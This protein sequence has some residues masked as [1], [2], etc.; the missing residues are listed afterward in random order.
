M[1]QTEANGKPATVTLTDHSSGGY[2]WHATLR[3]G[4]E[5]TGT[6]GD[7]TDLVVV[8]G[9]VFELP[10]AAFRSAA[11]AEVQV[12]SVNERLAGARQWLLM[13]MTAYAG[14]ASAAAQISEAHSAL[15]QVTILAARGVPAPSKHWGVA[16]GGNITRDGIDY[17]PDVMDH[18]L[19]AHFREARHDG[20]HG[21]LHDKPLSLSY[22][23]D[24]HED[25]HRT[26]QHRLTHGHDA[27]GK[28]IAL[29][30]D[31]AADQ[32]VADPIVPEPGESLAGWLDRQADILRVCGYDGRADG[33]ARLARQVEAEA[34]GEDIDQ[35]V[36]TQ[37]THYGSPISPLGA[38]EHMHEARPAGHGV[39][40][41]HQDIP[42]HE[43][44]VGT[45]RTDHAR[46]VNVGHVHTVR[47]PEVASPDHL[48]HGANLDAALKKRDA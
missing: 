34:V 17:T 32:P 21:R 14:N 38:Y 29:I 43:S 33:V 24:E 18:E 26:G 41:H 46:T 40:R 16:T 36:A 39:A 11:D 45:H 7:P 9:Q 12:A 13:A 28:V 3:T 27:D 1:T 2:A 19:L 35:P 20:G 6:L 4:E 15:V 44:W 23:L 31:G 30:P 5:E 37:V 8:L 25:S 10:V 47:G 48:V 42:E 22:L